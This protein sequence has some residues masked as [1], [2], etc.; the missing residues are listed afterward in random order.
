LMPFLKSLTLF[1]SICKINFTNIIKY[2]VKQALHYNIFINNVK[3]TIL[4]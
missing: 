1:T 4:L 2:F 3:Q